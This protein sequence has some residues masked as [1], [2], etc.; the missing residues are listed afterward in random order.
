MA[1]VVSDTTPLHYLILDFA[2]TVQQLQHTTMHLHREV[3]DQVI[4]E[5]ERFNQRPQG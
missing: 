4:R 1:G 3:V 2:E 5:F